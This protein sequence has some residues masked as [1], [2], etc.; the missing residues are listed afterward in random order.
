MSHAI[1]IAKPADYVAALELLF[2]HFP[3]EEARERTT[4]ALPLLHD[5]ERQRLN[6]LVAR[7]DDALVGAMLMQAL[8]GGTG[9]VWPP[10]VAPASA[11]V[12]DDLIRTAL[13]W[14]CARG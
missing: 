10:Q 12:E 13:A 9:V 6:L 11:S 14:L 2:Q 5:A 8:P 4:V 3:A 7:T 1:E